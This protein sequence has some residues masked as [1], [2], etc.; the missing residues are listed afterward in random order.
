M[1]IRL[2]LDDARRALEARDPVLVPLVEALAEQPLSGVGPPPR[3]GAPTFTTFLNETRSREFRRKPLDDQMRERVARLRTLEG[4]TAEVPLP[5]RLRLH[6]I[7]IAL[8]EDGD[9][10]ARSVLLEIVAKV[11]IVYGPWRALKRIFKEA[12]ARGDSEMFGALAA[13][14]DMA[15]AARGGEVRGETLG[16]LARRAWRR[17]RKLATALPAA[18]ADAAAD[19]LAWYPDDFYDWR[20]TW[21]ANQIVNR[22]SG[23]Y[24]ATKF[25]HGRSPSD[26]L[27]GRAFA[28]LWK[29]TPRPLFALL[30]RARSD[31]VRRFAAAALK[32]DFRTS[33]REVE[34]AW[35][36]RLVGVRSEA[37][38]EFVVWIL[39]NVPRFEQS[40]FRTLGLHEAVLALF[41]SPS[42]DAREYAAGY[43]RTHA[44]DLPIADL[45][46]LANNDH[47]AVGQLAVDLIQARDP[48]KEVGLDA[49]G[50]LLETEHG[51][52]AAAAAL[53]KH[54]GAKELTPEWFRSRLLGGSGDAFEDAKDLL[55]HVHPSKALGP[56]FFVDLVEE[57]AAH[58][59][60][61]RLIQFAIGELAKLDPATIEPE[62]LRRLLLNPASSSRVVEWVERGR[63]RPQAFGADFL[64]AVAYQPDF[65]ADPR[66][67]AWKGSGAAW[68]RRLAYD[69][70]TAE[71]V[72]AWLRDVR[73]V[74][75]SDLGFEWLMR[76]VARGEARYHDFAQD[77]MIKAFTPADFA[78]KPERA[79][80]IPAAA[81]A[82]VDLKGATFVF[83]GKLATMKRKDAEDKVR[84]SGGGV[85][86]GVSAKLY[87]LVIGDE[88]SPLYGQGKKGDKQTKAEE[89]NAAGANIRIISETAFLKMLSGAPAEVSADAALAGAERLWAMATAPGPADAPTARFAIRYIR[90]HH[91]DIALAETDRPVDP[92]AEIPAEFLTFD[93]VRPL[94]AETRKPLRDL[95]LALARWEFAR[96]SP[97]A[98]ELVRLAEVPAAD[99]R[100]FVAEALT[101]DDLPE[102]RRFRIDPDR[103]TPA[104]VYS[105]C[106]SADEST[107][108]LGMTLI[109]RSPRLR[110]PEELYRLS[111]SP[112]RA[113]R[114]FVIRALWAL[115]RDRGITEGWRPHVP[116]QTTVGASSRKK[117]E[118]EV[119]R[120][121][122]GPPARPEELPS[123]PG[124][125]AWFLRRILF[126]V[127]PP[128][129]S[130]RKEEEGGQ[131]LRPLPARRAKLELV[132]T[133]RDLA[134]EEQGFARV[135]LPVLDEFLGSRGA[136][137]RAACLVAVTRIRHRFPPLRPGAGEVAS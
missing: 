112:D 115:Y 119:E 51:R 11:P 99:V 55:L 45:I 80:A 44:R 36:A 74:S 27:K 22:E 57:A 137:E 7:L 15:F 63:L 82:E 9:P 19:V 90:R 48:R 14:I 21:V 96:W 103:L 106:E 125:L 101:A 39:Q 24:T 117:A 35:V 105:F 94:F 67:A 118:A 10:W 107:R 111:E 12:E 93:R 53:R 136:S 38:D 75:P 131:R 5:D 104:A 66:I 83:T 31:E 60:S 124:S 100:A 29:R 110:V 89:L 120:R 128:R 130:P 116:P 8:W 58:P 68:A 122:T 69:E 56:G 127:P 78:P 95:A 135:A 81:P 40:A 41:D 72:L 30:E 73:N 113:V 13:R 97:P 16:Y 132:E 70:S 54:F 17:L 52:S 49:W 114:A 109:G 64:K 59:S 4:P 71:H 46:R 84:A 129:P 26:D 88:G 33:L 20:S 76:L 86:S 61:Y 77:V 91:P 42:D 47:G 28:D 133:I 123:S 1:P 87:Y 6:E 37:I 65:E 34:P 43:A 23:K 50:A 121:G 98:E 25:L 102:N 126:E 134:I 79:A 32:A 3:E 62:A 18:Y 92:G 85:A 2:R 108:S